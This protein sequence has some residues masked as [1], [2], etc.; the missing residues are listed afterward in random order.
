MSYI[1]IHERNRDW[2]SFVTLIYTE[3]TNYE[4]KKKTGGA[5]SMEWKST[6][7]SKIESKE[8]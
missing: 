4:E 7:E 1:D 5:V 8:D 6:W 2:N 3:E